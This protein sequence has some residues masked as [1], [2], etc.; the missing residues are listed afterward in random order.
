MIEQLLRQSVVVFFAMVGGALMGACFMGGAMMF[1]ESV[2][3][4]HFTETRWKPFFKGVVLW[5]LGSV[6]VTV[7]LL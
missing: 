6:M 1:L 4:S 3:P 7:I 5:F 2:D